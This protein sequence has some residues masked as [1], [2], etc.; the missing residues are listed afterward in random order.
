MRWSLLASA[1]AIAT[2]T[3][4]TAVGCM[5]VPL[6]PV[7]VALAVLFTLYLFTLIQGDQFN[8]ANT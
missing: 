1:G 7:P 5:S 3:A 8:T 6:D 4:V 2:A